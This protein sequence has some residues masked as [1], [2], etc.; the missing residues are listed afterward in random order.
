M[1]KPLT[2]YGIRVDER[3]NTLAATTPVEPGLWQVDELIMAKGGTLV[4]PS[5]LATMAKNG[6]GTTW[7]MPNDL[8]EPSLL[9]LPALKGKELQ[10]AVEGTIA[11][12]EKADIEQFFLSWEALDPADGK[13]GGAGSQVFVLHARQED[14]DAQMEHHLA[15]SVVPGR[16]LPGF[17]ILDQFFRF[18]RCDPLEDSAWTLVFLGQHENF[19]VMGNKDSV[20]LTRPLPFDLNETEHDDQYIA[21]LATEVERSGFFIQQGEL[22]KGMDR[23]LV[24]GDPDLVKRL[25]EALNER[26]GVPAESWDISRSFQWSEGEVPSSAYMPLMA[27]ALSRRPSQY[28][29]LPGTRRILFGPKTRRRAMVAACALGTALLP[30]LIIGST[31]TAKIQESY[32]ER[33]R[34]RLDIATVEAAEAAEIYRQQRLLQTQEEYLD[35]FHVQ[36]PDLQEILMQVGAMA[37]QEIL[38]RN[39][40]ISTDDMGKTRLTLV[41]ESQAPTSSKAHAAFIKFQE[42]LDQAPFL[43]K[44]TEPLQLEIS[45]DN[46][47][48]QEDPPHQFQVEVHPGPDLGRGGLIAHEDGFQSNQGTAGRHGPVAPSPAASGCPGGRLGPDPFP[49]GHPQ[50]A[51]GHG[52]PPGGQASGKGTG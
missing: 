1:S 38:L 28:S 3:E 48:E 2:G 31:V 52:A 13:Q 10:R 16:L 12:Q 4:P 14:I 43:E 37:P 44:Y 7:L 49:G 11:R 51:H 45:G 50:P 33:A 30:V 35:R 46:L 42:A 19:L 22:G 32:L 41:G 15:T 34:A 23:I 47:S 9:K 20:I 17:M 24:A 26:S 21:R 39:L 18:T 8:A 36:R 27:A 6:E 25:V 29:L 40:K 5:L